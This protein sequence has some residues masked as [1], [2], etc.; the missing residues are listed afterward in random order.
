M[1]AKFKEG[2]G[3]YSRFQV[4]GMIEWGQNPKKSLGLQT[5]PKK[6]P[7]PNFRAIQKFP[8]STIMIEQE[9]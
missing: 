5:K 1:S 7:I 6:N 9:K 4:T 8:E 2:G 3:G